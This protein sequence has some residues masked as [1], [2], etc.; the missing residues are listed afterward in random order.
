[1]IQQGLDPCGLWFGGEANDEVMVETWDRMMATPFSLDDNVRE[2]DTRDPDQVQMIC[3]LLCLQVSGPHF[4]ARLMAIEQK[5]SNQLVEVDKERFLSCAIA[6]TV[7][8][9]PWELRLQEGPKRQTIQTL[10]TPGQLVLFDDI[11]VCSSMQPLDETNGKLVLFFFPNT[12]RKPLP[13]RP[14][15]IGRSSWFP[16]YL[17]AVFDPTAVGRLYTVAVMY[18]SNDMF[19]QFSP[20]SVIMSLCVSALTDSLGFYSTGVTRPRRSTSSPW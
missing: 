13:Y 10:D 7:G 18:N 2:A 11:T 8:A 4:P 5:G 1:L 12:E 6:V 15:S 19:A 3:N 17:P 20:G 14:A 9:T 16:R